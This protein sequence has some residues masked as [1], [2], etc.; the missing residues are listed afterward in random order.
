MKRGAVKRGRPRGFD[1]EKALECA[2]R[3][4]WKQGYEGT[5]LP[6]LTKAMGINRPSLY[7]AFGNKQSLFHKVVAR[8]SS[9]PACY[10][11][12]AV[13]KPTAREMME[14][15]LRGTIDLL[16]NPKNPRG[17][18]IVQGALAGGADSNS[19]RKELISLR[20]DGYEAIRKRLQQALQAGDL[21]R[22]S[23]PEDLARYAS[24]VMHGLSVQASSGATRDELTR[25]ADLAMRA[26][27][28]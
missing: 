16:S 26:W 3:V 19:V 17:C 10:V 20:G 2:M 23:D 12:E 13:E 4:F 18:L 14:H 7:A 24:T 11:K 15:L 22:G 5:T 1:E 28:A 27:P 25:V 8:Y 9:G 6:D 21:L